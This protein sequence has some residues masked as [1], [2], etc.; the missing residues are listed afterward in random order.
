[1]VKR[2]EVG[3]KHSVFPRHTQTSHRHNSPGHPS[4]SQYTPVHPTATPENTPAPQCLFREA[5]FL[6]YPLH[7]RP[8]HYNP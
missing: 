7:T 6:G 8:S 1:K 2:A 3:T 5:S 4:V